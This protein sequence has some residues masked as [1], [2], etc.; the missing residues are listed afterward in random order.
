MLEPQTRA[1][2]TEQLR[3]PTGFELVHAVGTT[4]T[5]GLDTALS[6]PLAFAARGV[7]EQADPIAILDAVRRAADRVD[8]F[9][10]AGEIALGAR[11]NRLVAF[12]EP[13]LH[14][15]TVPAGIFH[16]KVW[17]L[18]FRS[19]DISAFR[20]VCASRNLTS[21]RSWDVVVSL[22]GAPGN[23]AD[24]ASLEARNAPIVGL[25][26]SLPGSAVVPLV[27]ERTVR[28]EGLA[29]RFA[30]VEWETPNDLED[31]R[32]HVWRSG[33]PARPDL[34]GERALI[35]SPF[36]QD[37]AFATIRG[38]IRR[39]LLVVS[40]S[41]SLN[42]LSRGTISGRTSAFVLDAAADPAEENEGTH[43]GVLRGLHAK[44]IVVNRERRAR[45][46]LGSLNATDAAL[47]SNVEVMVELV[48]SAARFGVEAT[49]KALG[50][51]IVEHRVEPVDEANADDETGGFLDAVLRAVAGAQMR[52]DVEGDGPYRLRVSC[53]DM[54]P[55]TDD[56]RFSWRLITRPDEVREGLPS[57]NG[58]WIEAVALPD[59]TPYLVVTARDGEGAERST[60]VLAD[61][62]GDPDDRLDAVIASHLSTPADFMRFI[63]LLLELVGLGTA[64]AGAGTA[65]NTTAGAGGD[66]GAGLFESLIRSVGA[67]GR[68]LADV[69]RV[70]QYLRARGDTAVLPQ[71]F[72]ELWA[73]VWEAQRRLGGSR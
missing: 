52:I 32:F 58:S 20:F 62:H 1:T 63:T 48:G 61:L 69:D 18:E 31:L 56:V 66:A 6:V 47:H 45:V 3:P 25:L 28:I 11:N 36:L 41:E 2:L 55:A 17:F 14:P 15:V 33:A 67:R 8:V 57:E 21:D 5:L 72:D 70:V 26:R 54:V 53:V 24:A 16:P 38:G 60:V 49:R 39:E 59:V 40:R 46:L 44:V 50:D 29:A 34:S 43:L 19:G 10:Q 42:R 65:W 22:D 4:F 68:G 27:P 30:R 7:T 35:I 71:G 51:L 73:S 23:T 37:G 9:A 13:M 64:G 12:L